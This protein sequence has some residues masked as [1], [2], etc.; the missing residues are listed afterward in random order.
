VDFSGLLLLALLWVVFNVLTRRG[1]GEPGSTRSRPPLPGAPPP[2]SGDATQQEGS[3]LETLLRELERT[4][5]Q[6]TAAPPPGRVGRPADVPLP[7][8]EEVE[9][10]ESLETEPEVVS[11]EG[12]V[13]RPLRPQLSQDEGAA[14][15]VARR[16]AAAESRSGALTKADHRL[17]DERI[18]A[19]PAD[20]TAVRTPTAAELRQ[21]IIW[22]E[23]LGPPIALRQDDSSR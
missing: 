5:D 23:V 11:L 22:R 20:A 18:R 6:G 4:L 10:R 19:E 14:T 8:A 1:T 12:H 2:A 13:S 15:L 7:S 3:R 16:I 21:A 9:E 17:F